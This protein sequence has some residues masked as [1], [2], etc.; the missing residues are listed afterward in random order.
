MPLNS[1][2]NVY[3]EVEFMESV[4]DAI[5][6]QMTA[7]VNYEEWMYNAIIKPSSTYEN[8]KCT[9]DDDFIEEIRKFLKNMF[10]VNYNTNREDTLAMVVMLIE[11]AMGCYHHKYRQSQQ[12]FPT[13]TIQ[14]AGRYLKQAVFP[15]PQTNYDVTDIDFHEFVLP[16]QNTLINIFCSSGYSNS[17]I[18]YL[19]TREKKALILYA[20]RDMMHSDTMMIQDA[21]T[22]YEPDE[23]TEIDDDEYADMVN[24][25]V[26]LNRERD[27]Q[28]PEHFDHYI[29]LKNY[30]QTNNQQK[31]KMP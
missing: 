11:G 9:S 22:F 6:K 26:Y 28:Y 7:P 17:N 16:E 8:T 25:C 30:M 2:F 23:D 14:S 15:P 5:N 24:H 19:L 29:W 27:C 3:T 1:N 21:I 20:S 31:R 10:Y 4:K 12:P 18:T 13:R